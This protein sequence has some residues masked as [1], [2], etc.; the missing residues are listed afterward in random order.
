MSKLRIA[1]T[2]DGFRRCGRAWNRAP[3]DVDP[4]EFTEEQI[5]Q[6][7]ADPSIIVTDAAGLEQA[8]AEDDPAALSPF[9]RER[10]VRL[11]VAAE[12]GA[13]KAP[14]VPALRAATGIR[15]ISAA[16]RDEHWAAVQEAR[17]A[18]DSGTG[19]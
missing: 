15:N 14:T 1:A 3:V 13:D 19:D 11:A 18:A 12:G 6:L 17:K 4:S 10:L 16:E 2:R 7:R 8:P 5:E 9:F